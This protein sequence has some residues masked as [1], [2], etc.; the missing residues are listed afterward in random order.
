MIR[1]GECRYGMPA[2]RL[3]RQLQG[4]LHGV[5]AGR[6]AELHAVCEAA[7]PQ[8]DVTQRAKKRQLGA[9]VQVERLNDPVGLQI[10]DYGLLDMR[11][12]VPVAERTSS[13]E[14]INVP[15]AVLIEHDGAPRMREYFAEPAAINPDH[16]LKFV[17][18]GRSRLRVTGTV[19]CSK[20]V[21]HSLPAR[22]KDQGTA[23]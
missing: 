7:R 17:K 5:A 13:A 22:E 21:S 4:G 6:T 3:A 18:L 15:A 10:I 14:E 20:H 16:R 23:V 8:D 19:R 12:V 11:I 1:V 2:G 9:R